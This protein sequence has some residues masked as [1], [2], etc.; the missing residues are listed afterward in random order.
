METSPARLVVAPPVD[1]DELVGHT[2]LVHLRRLAADRPGSP[3]LFLKME[4]ANPGGSAKDRPAAHMVREAW[5]EGL[6]GPGSTII[7]SSSGNLG[8]ALAQQ[9]RAYGVQFI[10]VIDPRTPLTTR[11]L[12]EA[13]GG[14]LHVVSEPDPATGD[15]LVARIEAVTSMMSAVPGAWWP[16]QYGSSAN[17]TAHADGTMREILETLDGDLAALFTATSST[18]T[19]V[20]CGD[21][22]AQEGVDAA[23]YAVDAVGS[24]LFDGLRG[25]RELPGLGA[26]LVP[27]LAARAAPHDVLR[28]TDLDCV[29]GCRRLVERE[30]LLVGASAGGVVTAAERVL[31]RFTPDDNVVL[32]AHDGGARYLDTVYDDTWVQERL[33][34]APPLLAQLVADPSSG[35]RP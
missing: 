31:E 13:F 6:I 22:L 35:S 16:N 1:P 21:R 18:G 30:A 19:L 4:A 9:A 20:G 12:I 10:C 17:A 2:P 32:I 3:R 15:W 11:R 24:V 27:P 33:G 26:G 25:A 5:T 14:E 28:V 34:C 29:V 7:E 23:L 8:V